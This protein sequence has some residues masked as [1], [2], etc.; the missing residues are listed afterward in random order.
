[1]AC[2]RL[3]LCIGIVPVNAA[4]GGGTGTPLARGKRGAPGGIR[5]TSQQ[6]HGVSAVLDGLFNCW[7][8]A[9]AFPGFPH[10]QRSTLHFHVTKQSVRSIWRSNVNRHVEL[11]LHE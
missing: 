6:N 5:P 7:F 9:L 8:D 10:C 3:A 2:G 1:T 4:R 11:S